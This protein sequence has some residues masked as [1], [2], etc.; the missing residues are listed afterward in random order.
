[1]IP[2]FLFKNFSG[3]LNKMANATAED[4]SIIIFILSQMNFIA[5]FI[6]SSV[7]VRIS[8]TFFFIISKF[9]GPK[10]VNSPSAIVS[11]L[12]DGINRPF[13][14]LRFASS[15]PSGS[16]PITEIFLPK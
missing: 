9:I 1:M 4:G 6:S 16:A 8:E 3:F 7:T 2:T 10:D 5:Y 11:G 12:I 15:A 13:S 14:K